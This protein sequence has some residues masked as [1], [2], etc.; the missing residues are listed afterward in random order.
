MTRSSRFAV[1]IALG[2]PLAACT[3]VTVGPSSRQG[4]VLSGLPPTAQVYVDKKYWGTG[5]QVDGMP[6]ELKIGRHEI[7][8]VDPQCQPYYGILHLKAN[9]LVRRRPSMICTRKGNGS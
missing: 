7:L 1:W 5:A 3:H 9:E 6:R 4:L 8:I 2:M